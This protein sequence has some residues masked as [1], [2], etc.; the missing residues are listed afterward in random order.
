MM[1]TLWSKM[2]TLIEVMWRE[3]AKFGVVGAVAW[4][5][6]TAVFLWLIKGPMS[7]AEVW[8]KGWATVVASIFSWAANRWWTFRHRR[9]NRWA[10]EFVLFAVMN[11]IGLLIAAGCVFFTK[12][13][14]QMT[15][16]MALFIAGSVVGLVLGTIFRFI[17]YRLW[18]FN[19][20]S[21]TETKQRHEVTL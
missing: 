15:S 5:I 7:D 9:N 19:E 2:R 14:L 12:Y 8:A 1:R 17:A 21:A 3:V 11:A 13:V 4:V 20:A 6:D 18:V 10:R 16:P